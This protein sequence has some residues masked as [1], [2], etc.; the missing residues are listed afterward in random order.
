MSVARLTCSSSS[1]CPV[2]FE[3]PHAKSVHN[4]LEYTRNHQYR[5]CSQHYELQ[6]LS[7]QQPIKAP[8]KIQFMTSNKLHVSAPR[9]H[10]QGVFITKTQKHNTLIWILHCPYLNYQ[11]IKMI[12]QTKLIII[13]LEFRVLY[14]VHLL[15]C[16]LI[17][18]KC[19]V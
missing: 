4:F 16:V 9:C 5:N 15:A 2:T 8:N 10:L 1:Y 18:S 11:C 14:Q 13:K 7:V 3:V 12:K 6:E 17:V 19:T